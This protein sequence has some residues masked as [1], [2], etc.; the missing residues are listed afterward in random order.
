MDIKDIRCVGMRVSPKRRVQ[1]ISSNLTAGRKNEL[2][3][4]FFLTLL[5]RFRPARLRQVGAMCPL[6]SLN[7]FEAAFGIPNRIELLAC[8]APMCCTS[9]LS[10]HAAPPAYGFVIA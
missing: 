5:G 7:V 4:G 9:R 8:P 10:S 6:I 3:F 1:R 2:A